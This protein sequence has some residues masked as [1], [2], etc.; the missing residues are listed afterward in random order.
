VRNNPI[1]REDPSGL[2]YRDRFFGSVAGIKDN[3]IRDC[4]FDLMDL[5]Y[6]IKD[7]K[8]NA[9]WDAHHWYSQ[10]DSMRGWIE[11]VSDD[12]RDVDDPK[13]LAL[14]SKPVHE[15]VTAEQRRFWNDEKAKL[16]L[17]GSTKYNDVVEEIQKLPKEKQKEIFLRYEALVRK[18]KNDYKDF[19]IQIN[20][21]ASE[22]QQAKNN[23]VN[24][25]PAN[26]AAND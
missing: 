17:K 6:D 20:S 16:G 22:V 1:N 19:A 24:K 11:S 8:T 25:T 7:D 18:Q 9:L 23:A 15:R 4:I 5:R 13:H 10:E 2:T 3:E 21:T 14:L 26:I 12:V